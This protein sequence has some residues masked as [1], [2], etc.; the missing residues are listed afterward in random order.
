MGSPIDFV[1][2]KAGK[3]AL[4]DA[5]DR[6]I[7]LSLSKVGLGSGRYVA[8]SDK[9]ALVAEFTKNSISAGGISEEV[10]TINFTLIMNYFAEKEVS[11]LGLY[12]NTGVLF[13]VASNPTGHY[14]KLYPSIDFVASFGLKLENTASIDSIEFVLDGRAGI[15][16][17]IM[18]AHLDDPDPHPQYKE[19]SAKLIADHLA[20]PDPHPQYATK[21]FLANELDKLD[22]KIDT[23][24]GVADYLF[25]PLLECGYGTQETLVAMRR[26]G[27]N[28]V[29]NS[30]SIVYHYCPENTHEGWS[31]AR[32]STQIAT[33][34]FDRSGN[35]RVGY[36][37]RSNY[38]VIDTDRTLLSQG[39]IA[40]SNQMK[41]E[42][43]SG[44]FDAGEKNIIYKES[45]EELD[46]TSDQVAVLITP[47]G[48]HEGWSIARYSDR[49]EIAIFNRSGTSR[50]GYSGRVNWSLMRVNGVPNQRDKYPLNFTTGVESSGQFSIPAPKD[51]DFTNPVYFPVITPEGPHEGWVITRRK[52]GFVVDVFN[53]S[54]QNRIGYTGK[55]NW[56]IFLI[57]RPLER[58]VFYKGEYKIAVPAGKT[59]QFA[60]YGAGGGGGSSAYSTGVARDGTNAGDTNLSLGN[61][62]LIAGGGKGGTSGSW[63]NGSSYRNG[64]P[65]NGG[66]NSITGLIA[67]VKVLASIDGNAGI[68]SSRWGRQPGGVATSLDSGLEVNNAGGL[69]AIGIGDERWSYGGGGGS[70]AYLLVEYKN[71]GGTDVEFDLIVGASGEGGKS[72]G[73]GDNGGPSFVIISKE[74]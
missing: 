42:I 18:Q 71:L 41:N 13:A 6:S 40:K 37:G 46:Y 29:W 50:V 74:V 66:I 17:E 61:M 68:E 15:A 52:E 65:G 63:G 16:L 55:V 24:L 4:L 34:A 32:E 7:K 73:S 14:F 10:S 43:K 11:E 21:V 9:T 51:H 5:S 49:I 35:N 53:R 36:A 69:G 20:D 56:A 45:W 58:T 70:G 38:V 1:V 19:Y 57:D 47:E 27:A 30:K 8:N 33:S 48:Q 44:V 31:S 26:K 2:T 22:D 64:R 25:P 67:N 12:T 59:V 72:S 54:G 62:T 60:M 28:Y 3:N 23:L 39:L